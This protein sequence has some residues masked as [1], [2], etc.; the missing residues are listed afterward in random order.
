MESVL[1]NSID[2]HWLP[3]RFGH[4]PACFCQVGK[5]K[6]KDGRAGEGGGF[7]L[8]GA[9]DAPRC[10]SPELLGVL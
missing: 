2:L 3:P 4:L 10:R 5:V 7:L 6:K 9:E 1:W 8:L